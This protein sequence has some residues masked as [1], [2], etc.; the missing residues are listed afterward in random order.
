MVS[1]GADGTIQAL[2]LVMPPLSKLPGLAARSGFLFIKALGQVA[3]WPMAASTSIATGGRLFHPVLSKS[4]RAGAC[5]PTRSKPQPRITPVMITGMFLFFPLPAGV[6]LYM[7]VA[8]IFRALQTFLLIREP[9]PDNLQ[10]ILEQQLANQTVPA[11]AGPFRRRCRLSPRASADAS[12]G[13]A[14]LKQLGDGKHWSV[15]HQLLAGQH[16]P[17]KAGS[18][19]AP[20]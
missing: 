3:S 1:V 20:G 4:F 8:N 16:R 10:T 9:L 15:E 5:P 18:G 6:L 11:S 13:P 12:S 2:S 17:V 14:E 19:L 7:V